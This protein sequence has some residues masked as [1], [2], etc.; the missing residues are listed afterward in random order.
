MNWRH[1]DEPGF[2]S[3]RLLAPTLLGTVLLCSCGSPTDHD[4]K[5]GSGGMAG[6]A[7]QAGSGGTGGGSFDCSEIADPGEVVP[8]PGG[9]F[10]MGCNEAIDDDCSDDESPSHT[11]TMSS[12]EIDATEVTQ[13]QYTGCVVAG[14]C[15]APTCDWNCDSGNLPA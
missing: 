14:A 12:F 9:D 8:V 15:E 2:V 11:L 10:L 3:F 6:N 13:R 1:L 7:A 4:G 5:G